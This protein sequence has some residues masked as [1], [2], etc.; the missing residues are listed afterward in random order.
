MPKKKIFSVVFSLILI[1]GMVTAYFRRWDIHDYFALI[2]YN[3]SSEI[4]QLAVDGSFNDYGKRLFYVNKPAISNRDEFNTQCTNHEQTIVLGCFTGG[5]IYIFDVEDARLNGVEQ[6]TSAHEMLH[7][8][9]SRLS[10]SEKS[11]IDGL[12][13]T[14]YKQANDPRLNELASSYEQQD[15]GS[16]PN[17][18][19]SIIATEVSDIGAELEEYYSRYFINRL[20]VV[21]FAF[22]YEQVFEDLKTQLADYDTNLSTRKAEIDNRQTTLSQQ[23]S[24]ISQLYDR[25]NSLLNSGQTQDYNN[26]VP[27]YNGLVND[28]NQEVEAIKTL[29]EEYNSL[30][31]A[32]NAIVVL[33]QDLTESIDSRP[34]AIS[35]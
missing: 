27:R 1:V 15:P 2:S 9:Y 4:A 22:G 32:R 34:S 20:Q 14:V 18:L 10:S 19:H 6:V 21:N 13:D 23:E 5:N 16:V 17:E 28:Y 8:A 31:V 11:R 29:I 3:P 26:L 25:M 24:Q 7:V 35:Q 30:V 33:Q 12:V